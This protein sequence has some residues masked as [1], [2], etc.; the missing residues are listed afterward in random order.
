VLNPWAYNSAA[1][2]KLFDRSLEMIDQV[3][4]ELGISR[5]TSSSNSTAALQGQPE[6]P[7]STT[8]TPATNGYAVDDAELSRIFGWWPHAMAAMRHQQ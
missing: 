2:K 1:C 6:G 3:E 4:Y 8:T 7:N 5:G